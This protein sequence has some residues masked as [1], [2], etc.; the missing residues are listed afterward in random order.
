MDKMSY[1]CDSVITKECAN[2][3]ID[4]I[5]TNQVLKTAVDAVLTNEM[6]DFENYATENYEGDHPA[7]ENYYKDL[8]SAIHT[9]ISSL[10]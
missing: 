6:F 3:V 5:T 10:I 1:A 7:R 2:I 8:M 9:A 4:K